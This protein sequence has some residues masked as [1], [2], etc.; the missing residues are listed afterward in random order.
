M[1]GGREPGSADSEAEDGLS[2]LG[3]ECWAAGECCWVSVGLVS[4]KATPGLDNKVSLI[5]GYTV[6]LFIIY[7]V[8]FMHFLLFIIYVFI[9]VIIF[10]KAVLS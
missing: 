1:S 4:V 2:S 6:Y 8:L 5:K 7:T 9:S 3:S 10:N